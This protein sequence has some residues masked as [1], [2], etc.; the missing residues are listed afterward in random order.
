VSL[1]SLSLFF[2]L[3]RYRQNIA[4]IF[5]RVITSIPENYLNGNSR[6]ASALC[7]VILTTYAEHFQDCKP[8]WHLFTGTFDRRNYEWHIHIYFIFLFFLFF[9]GYA[10]QRGLW[11]PR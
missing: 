9:S 10:T 7:T 4:A 11:L 1:C 2:F 3:H 6:K 5:L 8:I